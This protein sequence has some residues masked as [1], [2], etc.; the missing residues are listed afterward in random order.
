MQVLSF[1]LGRLL[2]MLPV[3]FGVALI[4]FLALQLVP[5]DPVAIMLQGKASEEAIAAAHER[6]GLNR[7]ILVQFGDFIWGLVRLDMGTSIIQRAPVSDIIGQHL[8]PSV[9]LL[10]YSA[11]LGTLIAVPL[12]IIS[13]AQK[14]GPADH[15]IRLVGMVSFAMPP[16][17]IGLLLILFF[18]LSLGWF[19]ISGFGDGFFGHIYHLTLPATTIALFIA[20][21]LIQSMRAS[22]LDVLRADFIEVAR[23]KGLSERRIMIK[24]VLRNAAIPV[25]TVLGVNIGW[26]LSSA[27]IV[28]YVF[29][30]PGLGSLLVRAVSFRDFPVIQGLAVVF[31][32][33][34]MAVNLLADVG[35]MLVDRRVLRT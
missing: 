19:P 18:G 32:L 5:G 34:V 17:W 6:L 21:I 33:L 2:Q 16:F 24:H 26:L 4:A 9:F 11:L 35:Y 3:V 23:A 28:E 22:M 20:P 30:V 10:T 8:A 14:N 1:I 29:A 25:I 31:A 7:H 12:G 15:V 13:A 27:V